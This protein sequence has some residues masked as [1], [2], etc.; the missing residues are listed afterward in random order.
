M[1][2]WLTTQ[3]RVDAPSLLLVNHGRDLS[4]RGPFKGNVPARASWR[5]AKCF[6][7]FTGK[8]F[9]MADFSDVSTMLTANSQNEGCNMSSGTLLQLYSS[10]VQLN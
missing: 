3:R 10:D 5:Y 2:I 8:M 4:G 1:L 9:L 7:S 6:R